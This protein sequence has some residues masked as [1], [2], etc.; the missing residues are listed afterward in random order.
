MHGHYGY[1][2]RT[3]GNDGDHVDVVVA[4]GATESPKV[5]VVDQVDPETFEFDEHKTIFGVNSKE[6]GR[7]SLL[8]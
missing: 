7:S 2:K 4:P 6:D 8:V 1:F 3:K 5:F